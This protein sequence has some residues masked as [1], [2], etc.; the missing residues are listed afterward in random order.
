[1]KINKTDKFYD[2][3]LSENQ[4]SEGEEGFKLFFNEFLKNNTNFKNVNLI[5]DFSSIIN[6]DL[7][8]ILLFSQLSETHRNN[9]KS[10]VIV[11]EGIEFDKIPDEIVAVPTFKEAED[12][13]EI[14]DIERDLGF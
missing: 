1:M 12:I 5:L 8:K 4:L 10:F 7:N 14:E 13:I 6:I 3:S 11:C 2:L 9:N